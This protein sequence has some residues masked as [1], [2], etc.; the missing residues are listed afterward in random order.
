MNKTALIYHKDYLLHDIPFHPEKKERLLVTL[1]YFK[2]KG[3]LEKV[4]LITPQLAKEEDILRTHSRSLLERIKEIS[5]KGRGAI[6]ADTLLNSHTYKVALLAAGGTILATDLVLKNEYK[7]SFALVR[8]PGHH[9]TKD[10]AMGFCYFNNVALAANY[11]REVHKIKKICIMDWDAHA[12]NGTMDIFYETKDVLNISMHQNP[13]YFYPGTGFIAQNGEGEGKGYTINIPMEEGASNNDYLYL[14]KEFIIP[15]IKEFGPEFI[16]I[17]SGCDSH[18]D[19]NI[20]SLC[21]SEEGYG[22]MTNIFVALCEELCQ[23]RLTVV[24]E[25]GYNLEALSRSNYEIVKSLL[26]ESK[27]SDDL[28]G[29]ILSSTYETLKKL[30]SIF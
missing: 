7:N 20:S 1:N 8:P 24:L 14:L 26:R 5:L 19:D 6:D 10:K 18:K 28:N 11:L 27:Y 4:D 29:N 2:E 15:K 13:G 25:G 23:G 9:A 17:S 12:A 21:L 30:K 22:M 3:I 16:I